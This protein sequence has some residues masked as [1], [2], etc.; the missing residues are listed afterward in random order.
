MYSISTIKSIFESRLGFRDTLN[1]DY[2]SIDASETAASLSLYYNDY[3]PLVTQENLDAI[4]PN[5]DG[6]NLTAWSALTT[7]AAGDKCIND[8]VMYISKAAAN[9]NHEPPDATW[10]KIGLSVFLEQLEEQSIITCFNRIFRE[11]KLFGATKAMYD[12]LILYDGVGKTSDTITSE[13]RFVFLKLTLKKYNNLYFQLRRIGLQ[14]S[15]AQA[16]LTIYIYHTSKYAPIATITHTSD[17]TYTM[18]WTTAS[19]E[20][21]YFPYS[22]T[23]GAREQDSGGSFYIGYYED[24][25]TGQAIQR[26]CNWL[27]QPCGN[28]NTEAFNKLMYNT[29]TKLFYLQSGSVPYTKLNGTNLWDLD[30]EEYDNSTNWGMNLGFSVGCLLTQFIVDNAGLFTDVL[31]KQVAWDCLQRMAY[32]TRTN[33][34][35][36][37]TRADAMFALNGEGKNFT[38]VLDE[39]YKEVDFDTSNLGSPCLGVKQGGLTTGSL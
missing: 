14:A 31:A 18:E 33:R 19:N 5:Y 26:T 1:P 4:A 16:G 8:G 24:D 12:N 6:Y 21:N 9:I 10:W 30:D 15:Q 29:W 7:Y 38:K 13:S 37:Q 17:K 23:E 22:A 35:S 39:A 3:H 27:K 34:L 2:Q 32:S 25:L 36:E 20:L 11:K 28:C